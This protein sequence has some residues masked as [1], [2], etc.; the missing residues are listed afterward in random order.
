MQRAKDAAR[1]K[2]EEAIERLKRERERNRIEK[3]MKAKDKEAKLRREREEAALQERLEVMDF[4]AEVDKLRRDAEDEAL[5]A[6]AEIWKRYAEVDMGAVQDVGNAPRLTGNSLRKP[7]A[8]TR[9]TVKFANGDS[10][11][12]KISCEN[13]IL[14][15]LA[16][17]NLRMCMPKHEV[18]KF[19][20]Q[21][22]QYVTFKQSVKTIIDSEALDYGE[23]LLYLYQNTS[24]EPKEMV[25][26]ALYMD[27]PKGYAEVWRCFEREYGAP[28]VIANQFMEKLLSRGKVA[29]NDVREMRAY[30]LA[31]RLTHNAVDSIPYGKSELEHPKT[32]RVLVAKLP[33]HLQD[34]WRN[35][36]LKRREKHGENINFRH[37]IEF[38]EREVRVTSDPVFG[39]DAM[40]RVTGDRMV[41]LSV[42]KSRTSAPINAISLDKNVDFQSTASV[43]HGGDHN[44]RTSFCSKRVEN[45]IECIH[46]GNIHIVS[47]CRD[48]LR[49]SVSER[50]SVIRRCDG[51]FICLRKGHIARN[52]PTPEVCKVCG[53]WHNTLLHVVGGWQNNKGGRRMYSEN[54]DSREVGI[55]TGERLTVEQQAAVGGVSSTLGTAIGGLA[56]LALNVRSANGREKRV[57]A[58][59]DWGSAVSFCTPR[60][61]K[62]LGVDIKRLPVANLWSETVHS[63]RIQETRL[64]TGLLVRGVEEQIW[65]E[66]PPFYLITKIPVSGSD[67]I[68]ER[69]IRSYEHL[70]DIRVSDVFDVDLMLGAN[71]PS[72]L[73]PTEIRPSPFLGGPYGLKTRLG[74]T[75]LGVLSSSNKHCASV[76]RVRCNLADI[77]K[78][79]EEAF[80]VGFDK[81][82]SDVKSMSVEDEK[83]VDIVEKGY[84]MI[85]LH[86]EIPLPLRNVEERIP[87]S[88]GL[89]LKRAMGLRK[90]LMRNVSE[91]SAYENCMAGML[92]KCYAEKVSVN[93]T[94][95]WYTIPHF[96]VSHPN[97]PDKIRVVFDCAAKVSGVS[98][99]DL[100]YSGPD[101]TEQLIDV[102]L[103]FREGKLAFTAD[104]EAMFH[105]IKVP[106][107]HRDYLRFFW[108]EGGVES[109]N[110]CEYR[111]TVHLFGACSSPSIANY[112]L[113]RVADDNRYSVRESVASIVRQNFYVDDCLRCG[114]DSEELNREAIELKRLCASAGFN[115]TKFGSNMEGLSEQFDQREV[116]DS[117]RCLGVQWDKLRDELMATANIGGNPGTKRELLSLI[118]RIYDPLG[119]IAP[120]VLQGRLIFQNIIHRNET[121]GWDSP[122][123]G[124]DILS[125]DK[126]VGRL[127]NIDNYTAPRSFVGYSDIVKNFQLHVFGD[128]SEK[129][130]SAVAYI[131]VERKGG[132]YDCIFV[133]GRAR[134]N[135][136]KAVTIPRLELVAAKLAACIS[137][138]LRNTLSLEFERVILW[139]DSMT[140]LRYLRS[141]RLRFHSFVSHRISDIKRRTSVSQWRYVD[142]G[143]NPADEGSRGLNSEIWR[144][145]PEFLR[146][147]ESQWPEE[148]VT[149]TAVEKE[150]RLEVKED[151]PVLAV[152]LSAPTLRPL[153]ER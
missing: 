87:Y 45:E 38:V 91:G 47:H 15:E 123:S 107:M 105:Q 5:R 76:N 119:M 39:K 97:K 71:A 36:V 10:C 61:L 121:T 148:R 125:I 79:I 149:L 89:A 98:L 18:E 114:N 31:L 144:S 7:T 145:G 27:P 4:E 135:P 68:S 137:Q 64:I 34:R 70:S 52:Y 37:F 113:R 140:V 46:C 94:G 25:R 75:V 22:E 26:T 106:D 44:A 40:A 117:Q 49:M 56:A 28:E 12:K 54:K 23:K 3:E 95:K 92:R 128:A 19:C 100:L 118:A 51:C 50:V 6:E 29:V 99:N 17:N 93:G 102:L 127:K 57:S 67:I 103:R 32:I 134:V 78:L 72:A 80:E 65:M 55:A 24:G 116:S 35:F 2:H 111:M 109:G 141:E 66:L 139:R 136:L 130:H 110:L 90:K 77:K 152:S 74:W 115:L 81:W 58:F 84:R 108:W 146:C 133:Y 124:G 9:Q 86:Y 13:S 131:R 101:L 1:R 85:G 16:V 150:V 41:D 42:S 59:L 147:D 43:S 132:L 63:N 126:W 153:W 104:I 8:E 122:L 151:I 88:R 82:D 120:L 129:G 21:P 96:A 62:E 83:W 73:E 138:R 143:C 69:D 11:R 142:S 112:A 48:F 20:G 30:A 14:K 33:I 60:L 53:R